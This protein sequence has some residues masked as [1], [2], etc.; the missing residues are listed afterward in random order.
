MGSTTDSSILTR[1]YNGEETDSLGS[2]DIRGG[3][4]NII[5]DKDNNISKLSLD[6]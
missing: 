3:D 4:Q 1:F 2:C 6:I 5:F